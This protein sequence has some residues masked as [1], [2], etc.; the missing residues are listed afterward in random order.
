MNNKNAARMKQR[1]LGSAAV[2]I[3]AVI[4]G[5]YYLF[6]HALFD[7]PPAMAASIR[8]AEVDGDCIIVQWVV[9]NCS[10]QVLT[11]D[12]NQIAQVKFNGKKVIY[13]TE[14]ISVVPNEEVVFFISITGAKKDQVNHLIISAV[15]NEGTKATVKKTIYTPPIN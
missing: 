14:A 7:I 1:L 4:I 13:P 8:V 5:C 15:S 11:F 6:E 3:L 12:E 10:N 9:T 2:I